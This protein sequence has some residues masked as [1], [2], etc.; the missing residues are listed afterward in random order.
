MH[1]L[2]HYFERHFSHSTLSVEATRE[3][4]T[5]KT[6]KVM[7]GRND[8]RNAEQRTQYSQVML[9][10]LK[11]DDFGGLARQGGTSCITREYKFFSYIQNRFSH[12]PK[13]RW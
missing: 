11:T 1:V 13:Y 3:K 5:R 2:Q 10:M 8:D 12:K 6:K 9:S 4:E 7:E